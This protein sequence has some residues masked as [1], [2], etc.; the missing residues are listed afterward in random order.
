MIGPAE[1]D[2]KGRFRNPDGSPA[3]Q[4]LRALW[5]WLKDGP[6]P[7]W[8]TP[9]PDPP[10]PP[11]PRDVPPGHAAL[12][13]IG[14]ASYALRLADG[15]TA[16]FDPIFSERCS[17]FQW[18][19]PK[20]ARPPA[21]RPADFGRVD[22]VFVSHAHWDHMDGPSLRELR[23]RF[24][25]QVVTGLGNTANLRRE[26]IADCVEIDWGGT[27]A[28]PGGHRATFVPM[29]HFA[30]RW[31]NDRAMTLWGGFALDTA[32]GGR[33]LHCGD[34]AWGDHLAAIGDHFGGLDAAM[35]PIGA[36]EPEWF[37]QSVH[38][39]PEQALAAQ[40]A[41]RARTAL[42]MH[43]GTFKL[44]REPIGDP[45]RRLLAARGAQDFRVPAFGETVVLPLAQK[46]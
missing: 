17:P 2:A 10:H 5:A 44:T 41:L 38:I 11:P 19:G 18:I 29:R 21:W 32:D 27:H 36:Y 34:T 40:Q 39:T 9:P 7:A 25:P 42:A 24:A 28:L 20:R 37:M 1:R 4:Q 13:F 23:D 30:A 22:A 46:P 14:H 3:G 35:I 15:F 31:G 43:H 26:G 8:E 6:G 33:L 16:L 45:P 12:T